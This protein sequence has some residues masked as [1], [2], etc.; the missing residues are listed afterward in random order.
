MSQPKVEQSL[1][2]LLYILY[3]VYLLSTFL[4]AVCLHCVHHRPC[5]PCHLNENPSLTHANTVII[6]HVIDSNLLRH[7]VMRCYA[8][9]HF[10]RVVYADV[11]CAILARGIFL[12]RTC[13]CPIVIPVFVP[14]LPQIVSCSTKTFSDFFS[15]FWPQ[16]LDHILAMQALCMGLE[17]F[18]S[19]T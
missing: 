15:S 12:V 11:M 14:S 8:F 17:P 16:S 13:F 18:D 2:Y 19:K 5:Y 9:D 1:C 4:A 7:L 6:C 3:L 10:P